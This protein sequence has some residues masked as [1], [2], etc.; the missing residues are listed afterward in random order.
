MDGLLTAMIRSLESTEEKLVRGPVQMDNPQHLLEIK[1]KR[2][3]NEVGFLADEIKKAQLDRDKILKKS[4][5][6]N[7]TGELEA[8]IKE[9]VLDL[10]KEVEELRRLYAEIGK[11]PAELSKIEKVVATLVFQED[12]D[13]E[14]YN[15][16]L[17]QP[18]ESLGNELSDMSLL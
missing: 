3:F 18:K 14:K 5:R 13:G 9:G 17:L 6:N 11:D 15:T 7:K 4:G 16:K 8:I 12:I 1:A 2:K 10:T